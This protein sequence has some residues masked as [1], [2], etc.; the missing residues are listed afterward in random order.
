MRGEDDA[1]YFIVKEESGASWVAPAPNPRPAFPI[2]LS[3]IQR[4]LSS[5][6]YRAVSSAVPM[7]WQLAGSLLIGS[8][9][10]DI[11]LA[12]TPSFIDVC[13]KAVA[14]HQLF[15]MN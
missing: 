10:Q 3:A 15:Q 9:L 8:W 14:K 12:R 13:A 11:S 2:E 5:I 6:S 7:L 4:F 1:D